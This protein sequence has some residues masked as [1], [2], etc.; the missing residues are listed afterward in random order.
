MSSQNHFDTADVEKGHGLIIDTSMAT[1]AHGRRVSNDP[2]S[3]TFG[4][5]P[6]E[7]SLDCGLN[8]RDSND[9]LASVHQIVS[10]TVPP[11]SLDAIKARITRPAPTLLPS[12]S[13]V[14]TLPCTSS[15][16]AIGDMEPKLEDTVGGRTSI[17]KLSEKG[18]VQHVE[19]VSRLP[20]ASQHTPIVA[21]RWVRFQL[22]FNTYRKFFTVV[23]VLNGIGII[24]AAL[25]R[26]PYAKNNTGALILGNLCTA[27]L[28]RNEIF[29]RILYL[30]VNTL[31]RK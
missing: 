22:F 19:V 15:S 1:I 9:R 20:T 18:E 13:V 28:M 27:V 11:F 14:P 25:D 16:P 4:A 29:G 10:P 7:M 26:F 6:P 2:L 31:L 30:L 23:V 21:S 17:Q 3:P 8:A 12:A 5:T 24:F